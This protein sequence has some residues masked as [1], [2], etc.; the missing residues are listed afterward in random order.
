MIKNDNDK[1]NRGYFIQQQNVNIWK[2]IFVQLTGNNY[3]LAD[4][5]NINN[6]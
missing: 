5:I 4:C 3:A 2:I 1:L 6:L